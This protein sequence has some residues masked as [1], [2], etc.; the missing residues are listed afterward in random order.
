MEKGQKDTGKP[1]QPSEKEA[2]EGRLNFL[3]SKMSNL[4]Q[5]TVALQE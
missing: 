5:Q 4:E 3:E 1:L 2:V